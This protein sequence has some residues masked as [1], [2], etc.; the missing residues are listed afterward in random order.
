[1]IEAR[2]SFVPL[3]PR[4][5]PLAAPLSPC[6]ASRRVTKG[7]G[8]SRVWVKEFSYI[9]QL[10]NGFRH[11]RFRHLFK[12]DVPRNLMI[13][14]LAL[15]PLSRAH[16]GRSAGGR[17]ARLMTGSRFLVGGGRGAALTAG[18]AAGEPAPPV[19]GNRKRVMERVMGVM[20][21]SLK[22]RHRAPRSL[23]QSVET[24]RTA[25]RPAARAGSGS[26]K[27]NRP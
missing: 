19:R 11:P 27:A 20:S 1:M 16:D 18:S 22:A 8:G 23:V 25:A 3:R 2:T 10:Y 13:F 24:A 15:R 17:R 7:A 9:D 6:P 14:I 12:R 21:P 4:L 26:G 5:R